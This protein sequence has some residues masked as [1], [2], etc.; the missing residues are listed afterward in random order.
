MDSPWCVVLLSC[1][2]IE[3]EVSC[4]VMLVVVEE[5]LDFTVAGGDA[6]FEKW[7]F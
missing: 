6:V 4:G 5:G 3:V 1:K 7:F 2:V